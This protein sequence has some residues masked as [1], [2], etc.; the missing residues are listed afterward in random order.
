MII[1]WLTRVALA[2]ISLLIA[3]FSIFYFFSVSNIKGV[4][5]PISQRCGFKIEEVMMEKYSL[6]MDPKGRWL[7]KIST[8][9]DLDASCGGIL[10][11]SVYDSP[12]KFWPSKVRG[13]VIDYTIGE[14]IIGNTFCEGL[15]CNVELIS[16]EGQIV[17][18]VVWKT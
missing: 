1:K 8:A 15:A 5:E 11:K 7:L 10:K 9:T 2:L 16:F 6:G 14:A 13:D 17:Q 12:I 18:L 3:L 4:L